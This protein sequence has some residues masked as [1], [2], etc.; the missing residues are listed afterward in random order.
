MPSKSILIFDEFD[1]LNDKFNITQFVDHIKNISDNHTDMTL[2]FVGLAQTINKLITAHQSLERNL[3]QIQLPLMTDSE[4]TEICK[5]GI[6]KVQIQMED[7]IIKNIV[8]YSCGFP[9]FT[10]LLCLHSCKIALMEGSIKINDRHFKLA[11]QQSV[12]DTHE[13]LNKAYQKATH[14]TKENIYAEVL[15]ACSEVP[16]DEHGTFQA[17]DITPILSK[18]L[19][20]EMVINSFLYHLGKFCD[21]E[22]GYI[23]VSLGPKKNTRYKFRIPSMRAFIRLKHIAINF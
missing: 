4:L 3:M 15:Y 22:R 19:N 17:S 2:F 6:Q 9:H 20:K 13:S 8:T 10:H 12:E 18:V 21:K 1:R 11:I 23:L 16:L 7:S 14:A 5:A